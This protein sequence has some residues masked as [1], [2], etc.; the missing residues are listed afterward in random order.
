MIDQLPSSADTAPLELSA[1]PSA[2]FSTSKSTSVP[3]SGLVSSPQPHSPPSTTS[4]TSVA[5][6]TISPQMPASPPFYTP[7]VP[8][9]STSDTDPPPLSTPYGDLIGALRIRSAADVRTNTVESQAPDSGTSVSGAASPRR[10]PASRSSESKI[11]SLDAVLARV[12]NAWFQLRLETMVL[13]FDS[14][15]SNPQHDQADSPATLEQRR[16]PPQG[17]DS[18]CASPPAFSRATD[19]RIAPIAARRALLEVGLASTNVAL[20]RIRAAWL[21]ARAE[22]TVSTVPPIS[23]VHHPSHQCLLSALPFDRLTACTTDSDKTSDSQ[24]PRLFNMGPTPNNKH[25]R[26]RYRPRYSVRAALI[27][28]LLQPRLFV[29]RPDQY[30]LRYQPRY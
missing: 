19:A 14:T 21:R 8:T 24:V 10:T 16:A 18:R 5:L 11:S 12:R 7:P 13:G 9:A 6:S 30:Q 2:P 1:E 29:P 25:Y 20:D 26:P 4:T 17:S 23:S 28:L 22:L 27:R 15:A 3:T